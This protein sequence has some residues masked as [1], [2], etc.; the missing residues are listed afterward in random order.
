MKKIV[1]LGGKGIGM[2]ASTIIDRVGD[3][4]VI[5]FLN[6]NI[7]KGTKIG[8]YKQIEVIGKTDELPSY[9]SDKNTYVFIAYVGFKYEKE[10]YQR[11]LALNIPENKFYNIIDPTA[12]IPKEYCKIGKGVLIAPYSQLSSDATI[13][14]N[15]M[16][17][18]NS[19]VGHD[20]FLDHFAHLATNAVVGA[21]VHVGKMVHIGSNATIRECVKIGDY[22]IV[23]GGAV[24]VKDVPENSIVVGNP[25]KI[26]RIKE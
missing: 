12:I 6:D 2:I 17:L 13:S 3:A 20:S 16:L 1:V 15:C 23:G 19:F 5:G 24:V 26:L 4:R 18:A 7:E 10:M 22:S 21:D 8:K 9:L 11:I 25:A 14:N